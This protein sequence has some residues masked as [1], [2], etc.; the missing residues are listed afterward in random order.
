MAY[1]ETTRLI[2]DENGIWHWIYRLPMFKNLSILWTVLKAV[3]ICYLG[4]I[5]VL[6][7]L[8]IHGGSDASGLR[9]L[10]TVLAICAGVVLVICIFSYYLVALVYGGEYVAIY[11]MN[12]HSIAQHQPGSQ[13]NKNRVIG[14]FASAAG[15]LDGN[16]GLLAAGLTTGSSLV[17]ET[18][19]TEIRS[20]KIIP[21]LQEI[22]VHSFLTW[23]TVYVHPEDFALIA[24]YITSRSVNA[25]ISWE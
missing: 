2:K 15:M 7:A 4:I 5:V 11:S 19:F 16:P 9:L 23:Y 24:E 17:V 14:L 25:R 22:R 21:S 1:R 3:G 13:A 18:K 12:E 20:L 6:T 8:V 10:Y